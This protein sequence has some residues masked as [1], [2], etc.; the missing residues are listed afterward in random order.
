MPAL[1][2]SMTTLSIGIGLTPFC[3][4]FVSLALLS[5]LVGM[6]IG[7]ANPLSMATVADGVRPEDRGVALGLRLGGTRLA[8]LINPLFFGLIIQGFGIAVAFWA[9]GIILLAVITPIFIWWRKGRVVLTD[10]FNGNTARD[11][12]KRPAG[13][14]EQ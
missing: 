3:R 2:V 11:F 12:R 14:G 6:G 8:R 10:H 4:G 5:I 1:L 13:N 9:G 7:F